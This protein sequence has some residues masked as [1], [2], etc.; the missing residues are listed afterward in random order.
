MI[1]ERCTGEK[2]I[3]NPT[4][5]RVSDGRYA[6]EEGMCVDDEREC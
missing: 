6:N 4:S 5:E 2:H 3:K 1:S